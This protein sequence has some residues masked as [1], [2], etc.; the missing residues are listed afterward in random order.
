M[1]LGL[2]WAV[3][4]QITVTCSKTKPAAYQKQNGINKSNPRSSYFSNNF[5][6]LLWVLLTAAPF[7]R[8]LTPNMLGLTQGYR[9]IISR[10][11]GR[12]S[13]LY[14]NITDLFT[15]YKRDVLSVKWVKSKWSDRGPTEERR[16][17]EALSLVGSNDESVWI[18]L[19]RKYRWTRMC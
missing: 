15:M 18:W 2:W 17:H 14:K 13:R 3:L 4:R 7:D 19:N 11:H 8:L 10:F 16:R 5:R 9:R 1:S 6:R 12:M